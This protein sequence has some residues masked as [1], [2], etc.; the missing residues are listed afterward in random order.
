MRK[1]FKKRIWVSSFAISLIALWLFIAFILIFAIV[2]PY[3]TEMRKRNEIALNNIECEG[4]VCN[5]ENYM[6]LP[7]PEI[8][9]F[10]TPAYVLTRKDKFFID[11]TNKY[12]GFK[13]NFSEPTFGMFATP[14]TWTSPT[15]YTWRLYS[16]EAKVDNRR[17]EI[18]AGWVLKLPD[19]E[20]KAFADEEVDG[21]LITEAD[22]IAQH[23]EIKDGKVV[24]SP[25]MNPWLAGYSVVDI[26]SK[27]VIRWEMVPAFFPEE[28]PL[29]KAGISF[30]KRGNEIFLV[31][32]DYGEDII[33]V[34]LRSIGK[35]WWLIGG[36]FF[37]FIFFFTFSYWIILTFLKKYFVLMGKTPL[38]VKEALKKG[39]SQEIEFKRGIVE[40]DLLKS[41]TAFANTNDGAIFIGIDDD[42]KITGIDANTPKKKDIFC[43]K[44]HNL[45]KNK[46]KPYPIIKI[47]FEEI[48]GYIIARIFVPRGEEM[49]YCLNGV[50]YVRDGNS[51][52]IA[53][54][55]IIKKIVM[56]YV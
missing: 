32:T 33:T 25:Y 2:K 30:F 17:I 27:E 20:F 14:T 23:L 3:F 35:I 31:R 8:E 40:E 26:E 51:D 37:I 54:P 10:G 15:G 52:V 36:A 43:Q 11:F 19:S 21:V 39:E 49:L 7:L 48:R 16:K 50:V 44:I 42:G 29:P 13:L 5:I 45:V 46:I 4:K 18:L 56:E 47:D 22:N 41:I 6:R 12:P 34:T 24:L 9:K 38:P 28:K 55:E 53:Q 1:N